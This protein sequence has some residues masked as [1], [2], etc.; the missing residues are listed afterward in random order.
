MLTT[1]AGGARRLT[2][3]D[4]VRTIQALG[5]YTEALDDG[6]QAYWMACSQARRLGVDPFGVLDMDASTFG[7]YWRA[8]FRITH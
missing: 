5:L 6:A 8:I 2:I 3:L 7:A 1:F 4:T